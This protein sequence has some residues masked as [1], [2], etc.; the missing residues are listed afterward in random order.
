MVE[1]YDESSV[2]LDASDP[3]SSESSRILFSWTG[4]YMTV[5]KGRYFNSTGV[6]LKSENTTIKL[7]IIVHIAV[8]NLDN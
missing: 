1:T 4:P 6:Y 5:F 8:L 7:M 2:E 3:P